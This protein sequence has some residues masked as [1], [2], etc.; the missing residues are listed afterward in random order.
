VGKTGGE[1]GVQQGYAGDVSCF[2]CGRFWGDGAACQFCGQV[3]GLAAGV[4]LS[5]AGK[6]CI[7][8]L[9]EVVIALATCGIGYVIWSLIIFGKG[10]SPGKQ[11]MGMRVVSI[12][13]STQA[14]WGTM[15]L[16]EFLAKLLIGFLLGWLIIPYFWLLIDKNKQQLWDKMLDTVVV[17]DPDTLVGTVPHAP[18]YPPPPPY[19]PSQPGQQPG[20]QPVQQAPWEVAQPWETPRSMGGQPD[21]WVQQ[22]PGPSAGDQGQPETQGQGQQPAQ[23]A[24][25]SGARVCRSCGYENSDS[26]QSCKSCRAP[27]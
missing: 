13:T 21:P 24:R 5:S 17:D 26:S 18:G 4:V 22:Q 25:E 3:S 7:A 14:S 2:N 23:P 1:A 9:I 10:Q 16:R 6:R 20:Q 12:A 27:L 8:N 15:F 19:P 11:L